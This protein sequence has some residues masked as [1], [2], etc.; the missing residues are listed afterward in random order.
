MHKLNTKLQDFIKKQPLFFVATAA[1]DGRVNMSPKG[2]DSLRIIDQK[3][4]VWMNLSGS[5]NE[6]AAHLLDTNRMTLMF[7]AF[8]GDA[9]ILR[10]YGTAKT[11]HPRDS[12]WQQLASLFPKMAGCRQIFE[13]SIDLIQLSCG[14][15]VPL[16]EFNAQRGE[17][18][19]LP[20]YEKMGEDGVSKYWKKK[21]DISIDGTKTGITA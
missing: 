8:S 6:T 16:M 17:T 9:L 3:K 19:L 15:G 14:T 10:V 12:Q 4:I 18:E 21:N 13:L 1:A 2:L 11:Y 7:C 20:F 5:G